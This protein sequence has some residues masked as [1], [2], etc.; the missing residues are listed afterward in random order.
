MSKSALAAPQ[1]GQD[2]S[3]GMSSQRVPGAMAFLGTR[4][5]GVRARDVAPNHSNR[6][7]VDESA[8]AVG[9]ALHALVALRRT[10]GADRSS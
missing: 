9:V 6:M 3:S 7:V 8:M 2:Q 10:A 4:P 5:P 1:S